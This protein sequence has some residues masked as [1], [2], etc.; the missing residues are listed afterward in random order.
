MDAELTLRVARAQAWARAKGEL[1][2]MLHAFFQYV[3][4]S[5]VEGQH[6]RLDAVVNS[7][8]NTV[9]EEGLHE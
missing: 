6:A 3:P 7:F 8:I 2:A 9:E 5:A 1:D 4:N